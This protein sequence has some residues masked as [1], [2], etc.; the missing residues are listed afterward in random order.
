MK[1]FNNRCGFTFIELILYIS[2]V[3]I[4]LSAL[5]PFAWNIIE[6]GSK[7]SVEQEVFSQ[8]RYVSERI[9]YEIRRASGITS[10]GATSISLT[11]FPPDTTTVID[12]FSEKAQ[13]NKNGTGAVDLNSQDTKVTDLTFTDYTSSDNKTKHVGFTLT[14]E[15]SL[16][17]QRQ[18]FKETV[19][20]RGSAE[21]R[22]N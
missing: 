14:L 7:S 21:V 3:T 22:S 18:E 8:A 20:L 15:S 4:M 10:V 11:N 5:I 9:K 12:L 6:G 19:T 13:I 16:P 2:I 17:S 1:Q